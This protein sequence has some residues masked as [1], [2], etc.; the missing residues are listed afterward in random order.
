[1]YK[2]DTLRSGS[3]FPSVGAPPAWR[4]L[5]CRLAQEAGSY[6]CFRDL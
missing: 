1:M 5:K 2:I 3:K 6:R 4:I